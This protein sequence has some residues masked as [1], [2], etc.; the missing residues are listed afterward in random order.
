MN[1]KSRIGQVPYLKRISR[2]LTV[3]VA[4]KIRYTFNSSVE[5]LLLSPKPPKFYEGL[6]G[7]YADLHW[8]SNLRKMSGVKSLPKMVSQKDKKDVRPISVLPIIS[9]AMEDLW[10]KR[11]LNSFEFN[12]TMLL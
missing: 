7:A 9:K 6:H 12:F 11:K 5:T 3:G 1:I 8:F 10:L 2:P 4:F